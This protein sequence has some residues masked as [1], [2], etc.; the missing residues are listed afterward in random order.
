MHLDS[1]ANKDQMGDQ[2][3]K[4]GVHASGSGHIARRLVLAAV[5]VALVGLIGWGALNV[6]RSWTRLNSALSTLQRLETLA[7]PDQ[8]GQLDPSLLSVVQADLVSLQDDLSI[9]RHEAGPLLPV[10]RQLGWVPKIGEEIRSAPAL[11]ETAQGIVAAGNLVLRAIQPIVTA[12]SQDSAT[13]EADPLAPL[14]RSLVLA[15]P[16]LAEASLELERAAL[17]RSSI[18]DHLTPRLQIRLEMLDRY[19]PSLNDALALAQIAP[20]LLGAVEPRNYLIIAQNNHELRATGGFVSGV[21]MLRLVDG[22]IEELSFEDSYAVYNPEQPHAPPPQPLQRYMKADM[23]LFRD[24]NW[25]PDFPTSTQSLASLYTLDKG[26]QVDGLVAVDITAV[27]WL[28]SALG[29]LTLDDMP[30]P[31]DGQTVVEFMKLQWADPQHASA[32]TEAD[33]MDWFTHRKDF[34]SLLLKAL[35]DKLQSPQSVDWLRLANAVK[36]CLD[37]KHVLLYFDDQQAASLVHQNH[38]DGSLRSREGS[39]LMLVDSNVGFNKANPRIRQSIRYDLHLADPL[40]PQATLRI[41]YTHTSAER[42]AS[43]D[44]TPRYDDV[45]ED[46]MDRC[47]FDYVRVYVPQ[48]TQ[49]IESE[50]FAPG[51]LESYPGESGTQVYAGFFVI[52]PGERHRLTLTLDLNPING[53]SGVFELLVQKQPGTDAHRLHVSAG[54]Q[55][56]SFDGTLAQDRAI[57]LP[58]R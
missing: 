49:L 3:D 27:Q 7:S 21:G 30:Q 18:T 38:W 43:C 2:Q 20:D 16:Q 14:L 37:E 46:M 50:G 44:H 33:R 6:W 26:I 32:I 45:Y 11:L 23:L 25:S 15:Q 4:S 1:E 40:S 51:T 9:V 57:S 48:G 10:T 31:I 22:R 19:L 13:R 52:A 28:V 12:L 54:P 5:V 17:A 58:A 24:A 56:F 47:Y 41:D 55:D 53:V 8:L 35:M 39:F 29:P 42:P 36:R 34:M